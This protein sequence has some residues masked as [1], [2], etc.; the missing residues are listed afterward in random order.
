MLNA[1]VRCS[2]CFARG[3]RR[4]WHD[5]EAAQELLAEINAPWRQYGE[6]RW[7]RGSHGWELLGDHLPDVPIAR[8]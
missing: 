8:G 6:L 2:S 3:L 7:R 4:A 5:S 1:I